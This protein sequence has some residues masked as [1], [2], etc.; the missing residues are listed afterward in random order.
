MFELDGLTVDYGTSCPLDGVVA[1][2]GPEPV[3]VMGP[4]GS[5]KSSLLRVLAGQQQQSAGTVR[6]N[7]KVVRSATWATAGDHRI[8]LIHQD[9][10]LVE[11]LNVV[12]NLLLAAEVRGLSKGVADA[13]QV[14]ETVGLAG[15]DA[16]RMPHTLSGGEQQRVAIARALMCDAEVLLADEPTG[17]LDSD[18]TRRITDL[19]VEVAERGSILLVVATHDRGV[20]AKMHT[21]LSLD[22]GRLE[23]VA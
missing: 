21:R 9:Y 13:E 11:F 23:A 7:R 12:D 6:L 15:I 3:A 19:L 4:S 22:Q 2:L 18:T 20:A 5:G 10:R 14:L 16:D 8:A 17:A 1:H